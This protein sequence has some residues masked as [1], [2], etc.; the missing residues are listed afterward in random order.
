MSKAKRRGGGRDAVF[1]HG[2]DPQLR[3]M[4]RLGDMTGETRLE[5]LCIPLAADGRDICL[6]F[7]SKGYFIGSCTRSHAPMQGRNIY[8]VIRYIRVARGVV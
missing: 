1:N 7:L 3:I 2:V 4:E 6:R 5:K 8:S